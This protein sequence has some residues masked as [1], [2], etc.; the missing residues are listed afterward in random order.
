[1]VL[2]TEKAI[3]AAGCFWGIQ[4][5]FDAVPGVISTKVGYTGGHTEKTS[6]KEVCTGETGHAEAVE[7]I[8]DP[9]KVSYEE[10]LE[11]FWD[12]HDPTQLNRQGPDF[13]TQYRSAI[14]YTSL[15]QKKASEASMKKEE[16]KIG[17]KIATEI[18]KATKFHLAE[19][20]HQ[21]YNKKHGRSCSI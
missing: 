12:C 6:Y 14:F 4:D 17:R 16:K 8:F 7:V 5:T 20:Y 13:G 10:L 11:A 15:A 21:H 3:F 9:K 2:S 19:D 18:S 1:M